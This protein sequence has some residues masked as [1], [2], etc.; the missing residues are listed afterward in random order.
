MPRSYAIL[1]EYAKGKLSA[2][3][4]PV[5]LYANVD[6]ADLSQLLS[7]LNASDAVARLSV[8]ATMTIPPLHKFSK[9]SNAD[10]GCSIDKL[11]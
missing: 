2:A 4:A 11:K 1:V 7:T 10:L 9:L 8:S 6:S 3:P 5:T